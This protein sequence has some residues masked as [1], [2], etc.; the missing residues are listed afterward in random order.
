[1]AADISIGS[2]EA[3]RLEAGRAMRAC[4]ETQLRGEQQRAE[5]PGCLA[6]HELLERVGIGAYGEVWLARSA[7]GTLRAVKVVYRSRFE[8]DRPYQREFQGILKYEPISRSH[9]GLVQILHVG[10]NDQAEYFYYVMELADDA[11]LATAFPDGKKTSAAARSPSERGHQTYHPRTLRTDLARGKC[12]SAGDAALVAF[13]LAEALGHLHAHG[14][15]HRDVKPSNV[16]FVDGKPKLADIGLVTT[17]GDSHSFVGTEGFVPPE[18]PG[19]VRADIFGLGKLLYEMATGRDRLDFPQLPAGLSDA[20]EH[21]AVLELNEVLLRACA[22]DSNSRYAS[23]LEFQTDLGL[24]IG[25]SSLRNARETKGRILWL[26]WL[27]GISCGLLVLGAGA[28]C[29][30]KRRERVATQREFQARQQAQEEGLLR[31][32]AEQAELE[33]R[34]QLYASLSEQASA[35]VHSGLLGQRIHALE[36]IQKAATISNSCELRTTAFA[37]LSL[38]DL[39]TKRRLPMD[40]EVTLVQMDPNFKRVATCSFGDAVEIRSA[41]DFHL[42]TTLP[43]SR[44]GFVYFGKWSPDGRYL[45]VRRDPVGTDTMA[46]L[47]V[48]EMEDTKRV[49]LLKQVPVSSAAF[50]PRLP[51]LI[52]NV[53]NRT[54]AVLD[55]QT[56]NE[57]RRLRVD[58]NPKLLSVCPDGERFALASAVGEGSVVSINNLSDGRTILSRFFNRVVSELAWHPAGKELGLTDDGG[59]VNLMDTQT[60]ST[61]WLGRHKAQ[62]VSAVFSPDGKYLISGGWERELIAWDTSRLEKALEMDLGSFLF[63]FRADGR[64]CLTA[65]KTAVQI[66]DFESPTVC[67]ELSEDLGDWVR[68][69]TFS[70]NGRWLAVAGNKGLGVWDLNRSGVGALLETDREGHDARPV[71]SP[72]SAKIFVNGGLDWSEWNIV[73]ATDGLSAPKLGRVPEHHFREVGSFCASSNLLVFTGSIGSRVVAGSEAAAKEWSPTSPGLSVV[74]ASG[75]WLGVFRSFTRGVNIYRLPGFEPEV[76]ITNKTNVRDIKFSPRDRE[77]AI[78]SAEHIEFWS[79]DTWKRTRELDGF[80]ALLFTPKGDSLWLTRDYRHGGLYDRNTLEQILPLPSGT[81]PLALSPDGRQLAVSVDSRR[82]QI[83]DLAA[84]RRQFRRLGIDWEQA[85]E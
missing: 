79:T 54:V 57:I 77:L 51:E 5:L 28:L 29:W 31:R 73:P 40:S 2:S 46:D 6:D 59:G 69:A 66:H 33:S 49:L 45:A 64:E 76:T 81:L 71:F 84:L 39:A 34:Q 85:R 70:R 27:A 19:T 74:D 30:A 15:V 63:Q 58:A 65:S 67:R 18:G 50:H 72:D 83:W 75:Q 4:L 62:A 36:A 52:A 37:A 44:K 20:P 60:G 78:E 14:L 32:R 53:G 7:L 25:G 38:P 56:G 13:R 35:T 9:E 41:K 43:V 68:F 80:M 16:I 23:T 42:L 82:I 1:M 11:G 21:Q 10:R 61:Q 47:E 17:L 12:W 22:P 24:F 26:K 3:G 48:W 8:D 55:L